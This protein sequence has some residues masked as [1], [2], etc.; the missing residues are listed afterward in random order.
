MGTCDWKARKPF[1]NMGSRTVLQ[2]LASIKW[3][4]YGKHIGTWEILG[5]ES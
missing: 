1:Y 2:G 4:N 3:K 5:W